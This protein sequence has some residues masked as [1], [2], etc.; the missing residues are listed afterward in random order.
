MKMPIHLQ[1]AQITVAYLILRHRRSDRETHRQHRAA[2][3]PKTPY[4]TMP[5]V[6]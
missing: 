6:T 1:N 2:F 3:S 5:S 4:Q